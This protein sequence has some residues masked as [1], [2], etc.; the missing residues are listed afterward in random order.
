MC[1]FLLPFLPLQNSA[2]TALVFIT[3]GGGFLLKYLQLNLYYKW[4]NSFVK[5]EK[6]GAFSARNEAISMAAG[7]VFTLVI[8][9]LVDHYDKRGQIENSFIVI[10]CVIAFLTILDFVMLLLIKNQSTEDALKQ[11]QPIKKVI[12]NT[13][14][15]SS[16][17]NMTIMLALFD[18][19]MY[20]T[21]GFLG[22]FKTEDLLLSVGAVQLINIFAG[23]LRCILSKPVGKWADKTSFA[24]VYRLGLWMYA[25][26]YLLLV[27][28]TKNTWWL[29]IGFAVCSNVAETGVSANT[30]NMTYSYVP[31][32]YFVQAQAIRSSIA[33]ILGFFASLLGSW[34]LAAV[35]QNGNMVFGITVYGQQV[36]ALLSCVVLLAA[37][38]LNKCVVAKQRVMIQ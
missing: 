15:N 13:L 33:G 3:I 6:R 23:I 31:I 26:S 34:I 22:T 36:L 25:F 10:A 27:F 35:Q 29:I 11:Q 8:G 14:G 30:N 4:G 37:I 5:P 18:V 12:Q 24:Y 9:A 19:S 16:F 7:V 2:R 1:V 21:T 20:L 38:V 17:R 32:D 28:T